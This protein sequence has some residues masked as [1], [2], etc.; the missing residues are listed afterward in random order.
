MK[1]KD[2]F[3]C[4]AVLFALAVFITLQS[5]QELL[6]SGIVGGL[7]ALAAAILFGCGLRADAQERAAAE[8][9]RAEEEQKRLEAQRQTHTEDVERL[10]GML[11]I[12]KEEVRSARKSAENEGQAQRTSMTVLQD[13]LREW[14]DAQQQSYT[15]ALDQFQTNIA[16][17]KGEIQALRRARAV[18]YLQAFSLACDETF[19]S[20]N[21]ESVIQALQM[22]MRI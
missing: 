6:W 11:E 3:W 16:A 17:V 12:L 2:L 4:G 18:W 19:G 21:K 14:F 22:R 7:C 5:V 8:S 1:Q 20:R 9:K 13:Y 10:Q 15:V